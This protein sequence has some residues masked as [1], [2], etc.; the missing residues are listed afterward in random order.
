MT[1]QMGPVQSLAVSEETGWSD[2][3]AAIK[4]EKVELTSLSG[5][6]S[7]ENNNFSL[8]HSSEK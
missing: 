1:I 7:Q 2:A 8:S 4:C 6:F 5:Y 3:L